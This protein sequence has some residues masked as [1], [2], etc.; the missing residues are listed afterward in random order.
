[1]VQYYMV[2][3]SMMLSMMSIGH[4]RY[5]WGPQVLRLRVEFTQDK[6]SSKFAAVRCS[7][8]Q[9]IFRHKFFRPKIEQFE[10][11]RGSLPLLSL[12]SHCEESV[13]TCAGCLH[14]QVIN[15]ERSPSLKIAGIFVFLSDADCSLS[16]DKVFWRYWRSAARHFGN[17]KILCVK[18]VWRH[19]FK[20]HL[21]CSIW[22]GGCQLWVLLNA[23]HHQKKCQLFAMYRN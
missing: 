7:S 15:S 2:V 20:D 9:Q 4:V 21:Q 16:H 17:C 18:T 13:G 10:W 12:Q 23:H 6:Y 8:L 11:G 22:D 19:H 5:F 14:G 1:M 3:I